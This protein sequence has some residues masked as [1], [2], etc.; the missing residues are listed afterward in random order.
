MSLCLCQHNLVPDTTSRHTGWFR[1]NYF[2][3]RI[4]MSSPISVAMTLTERCV[5]IRYTS[6]THEEDIRKLGSSTSKTS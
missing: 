2:I 1:N 6:K 3:L 4:S 5:V